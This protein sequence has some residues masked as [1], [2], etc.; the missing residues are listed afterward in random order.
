M[1][2]DV[3]LL[4]TTTRVRL[5]DAPDVTG[6]VVRRREYLRGQIYYAV[7]G[8]T[9]VA[10]CAGPADRDRVHRDRCVMAGRA[11]HTPG[12]P[13]PLAASG[14]VAGGT[15]TPTPIEPRPLAVGSPGFR[16]DAPAAAPDISGDGVTSGKCGSPLAE[17]HPLPASGGPAGVSHQPDCEDSP[18]PAGLAPDH[19][20]WIAIPRRR[21][22]YH[23]PTP[24]GLTTCRRPMR[25]GET[26]PVQ[27]AVE[28][29]DARPCPRCWPSTQDGV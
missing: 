10:L 26:L 19:E 13:V 9:G 12:Q 14:Q 23:Q 8:E 20:V 2:T 4:A 5:V 21:I 17:H 3:P 24:A 1:R 22:E 11:G 6:V 29:L 15:G 27:A 25:T 28:Q 18:L 16:D 7:R